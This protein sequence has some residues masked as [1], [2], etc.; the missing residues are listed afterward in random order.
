VV[1][2]EGCG[3]VYIFIAACLCHAHP[4]SL[5]LSGQGRD[6]KKGGVHQGLFCNFGCSTRLS[7]NHWFM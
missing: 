2:K 4:F 7:Q 5:S 6:G 3:G 1:V